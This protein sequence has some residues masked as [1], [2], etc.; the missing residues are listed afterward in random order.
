MDIAHN[1]DKVRALADEITDRFSDKRKIFIVGL[2]GARHAKAGKPDRV[3]TPAESPA[4]R[5]SARAESN[6]WDCVGGIAATPLRH[7]RCVRE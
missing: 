4:A 7:G 3:A 5:L 1:Q 6:Y 2:S